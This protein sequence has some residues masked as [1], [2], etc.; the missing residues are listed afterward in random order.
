MEQYSYHF[1]DSSVWMAPAALFAVFSS[2]SA[3]KK[4]GKHEQS[5]CSSE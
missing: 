3:G 1:L 5:E 2:T 4:H